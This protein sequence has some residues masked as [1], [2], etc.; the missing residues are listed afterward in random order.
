MLRFWMDKLQPENLEDLSKTVYIY[1]Q[2][3]ENLDVDSTKS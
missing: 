1:D 2:V 3:F